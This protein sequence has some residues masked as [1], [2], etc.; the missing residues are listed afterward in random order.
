MDKTGSTAHETEEI[1]RV[2]K[3]ID[4][5]RSVVK[6][7][8]EGPT[9]GCRVKFSRSVTLNLGN[10]ESMKIE[11]G[12]DMPCEADPAAV[13]R[14]FKLCRTFVDS[15]LNGEIDEVKT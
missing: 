1:R 14:A 7:D 9:N 2:G 6:H 8:G 5:K 12:L 3:V 11:V 15:R 4:D 10:Y 13:D